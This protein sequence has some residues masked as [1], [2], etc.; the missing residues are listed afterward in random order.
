MT[1][2]ARSMAFAE[3][4]FH[5][6]LTALS[7]LQKCTGREP[8]PPIESRMSPRFVS[9]TKNQRFDSADLGAGRESVVRDQEKTRGFVPQKP[10]QEQTTAPETGFVPQKTAAELEAF[11]YFGYFP[12]D[13]EQYVESIL[14]SG[15]HLPENIKNAA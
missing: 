11:E 12:E 14:D 9:E 4:S 15:D 3:R 10:V 5:K 8:A 6:T 2:I 13:A 7:K 1:L